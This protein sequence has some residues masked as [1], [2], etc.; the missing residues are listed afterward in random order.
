[1]LLTVQTLPPAV[2]RSD[3]QKLLGMISLDDLLKART[4]TLESERIRE[5]VLPLR[6]IFRHGRSDAR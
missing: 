4:R 1:M 6:R 5:R 2:E 3:A